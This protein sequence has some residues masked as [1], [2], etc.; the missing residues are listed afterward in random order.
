MGAWLVL[1][2]PAL[3]APAAHTAATKARA[4]E[5]P[6]RYAPTGGVALLRS[7]APT[8]IRVSGGKF[9]M[10][11][12]ESDVLEA[13]ASCRLEPLGHSCR[14][15][16]F[17]NELPRHQVHLEPYY[18]DR[19]EVTV[20]AYR[21]C[22]ELGRCEPPRY[23]EG[24]RR[25]E[26]DDFPVTLV[27]W[28]DARTYC[29]FRGAR[30]PTEAEFERAA[31][32]STGRTFPWGNLYNSHAANHGRLGIDR[33]D[34]SDG[35]AELAPVG[36]FPAGRTPDGFL[37]LA[38]NVSEWVEDDYRVDYGASRPDPNQPVAKVTR[39]GN[40]LDAAP[41][42]RAAARRPQHPEAR[43]PFLGFRCARSAGRKGH[44]PVAR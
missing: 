40:Y 44:G 24:A 29:A 19:T 31:R 18:L 21:R 9:M 38:G 16:T 36:S 22:V 27:S 26:R 35:Y 13:A 30:L 43:A 11:S 1:G 6:A 25:F 34:A 20:A 2:Q 39:G 5:L 23:A 17:A 42:L 8:M 28:S 33:T 10:G 32:G 15:G 4:V 3:R 41:W 37:D 14:E 12:H 7:P